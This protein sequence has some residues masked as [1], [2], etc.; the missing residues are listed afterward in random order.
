MTAAARFRDLYN[1]EKDAHAKVLASLGA[2]PAAKRGTPEY[3]KALSM[4]AHLVVA[5]QAWFYRLGIAPNWPQTFFPE[6]A[7]L[8]Q[9][10][11]DLEAMQRAWSAYLGGLDD[12]ALARVVTYQS[13]EGPWFRNTVGEILTQLYGHSFYHRGQIA[14][15]IRSLG[16][17]PAA[18][19]YILWARR[20][21]EKPAPQTRRQEGD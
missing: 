15:L 2:V 20:A 16:C 17:E 12:A 3:Q 21:T 18:T 14:M 19:D 10:Q 13:T 4:M 7:A 1:Y 11:A 6:D 9:L 5:R 8:G